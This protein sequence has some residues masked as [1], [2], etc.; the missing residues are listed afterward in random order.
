MNI[1]IAD[2]HPVV[3]KGLCEIIAKDHA[4][5]QVLE[6]DSGYDAIEMARNERFDVI[7]LDISMPGMNGIET[8]KQLKKEGI[9]VPVLILSMYPEE[10][11]ALRAIKAGASGYL[12]KETPA[13]DLITAVK[14]ISNGG[15]YI[16]PGISRIM[17]D[18]LTSDSDKMP[19][20]L[21]SDREYQVFRELARGKSIREIS[22]ALSI[23]TKTVHTYRTRILEK[24]QMKSNSDI[25]AYAMN[26]RLISSE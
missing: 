16:S 5:K 15:K 14:L 23:G 12:T 1:L 7:I 6:V 9:K 24:L 19:H 10:Q 18:A 20:E 11:Y 3:R 2:D 26:N 21:L 4:V 8:L 25:V 17:A 22:E 13:D